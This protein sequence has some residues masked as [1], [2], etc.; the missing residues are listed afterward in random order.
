[1]GEVAREAAVQKLVFIHVFPPAPEIF[2]PLYIFRTKQV[3]DGQV[4]MGE[5][6][7]FFTLDP[8]Q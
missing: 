4:V 3:Y 7:M 1:V 2:D 5:D 6:G 8:T